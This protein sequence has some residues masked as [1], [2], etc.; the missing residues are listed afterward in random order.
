MHG[1]GSGE[2][3]QAARAT[4]ACPRGAGEGDVGV[5]VGAVGV[6]DPGECW[7]GW[8]HRVGQDVGVGGCAIFLDLDMAS[9]DTMNM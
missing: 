3:H 6:C 8:G 5:L 4:E 7:Q 1:D 9:W 2:V